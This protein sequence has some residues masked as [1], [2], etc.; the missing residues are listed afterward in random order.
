M[1]VRLNARLETL[2]ID[3]VFFETKVES[4][5]RMS[6]STEYE[7][8]FRQFWYNAAVILDN[9]TFFFLLGFYF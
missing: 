4:I 5:N 1:G 2:D 7:Y 6:T 8:E 3:D 9:F